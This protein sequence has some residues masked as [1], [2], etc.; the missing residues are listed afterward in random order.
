ME[1]TKENIID[2]WLKNN[3]NPKINLYIKLKIMAENLKYSFSNNWK[4]YTILTILGLILIGFLG[5][6]PREKVPATVEVTIP[7]T[8]GKFESVKPKQ[9][10]INKNYSAEPKYRTL[11]QNLSEKERE[12]FQFQLD[13]LIS[14]NTAYEK[15]FI[16]SDSV[17]KNNLYKEAIQLKS[18]NQPFENDKIKINA[19]GL[20]RGT[21]ESIGFDYEIKEQKIN[22]EIPRQKETYLRVLAGGGFGINKA[23]NQSV[24]KAN[25]GF[26]NKKGNIVR[27]SFQK[28]GSQDYYLAEY[29]ISI[30]NWKR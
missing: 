28:I 2:R 26:Q 17:K 7:A 16:Y 6:C 20:V 5:G 9:E 18:F 13:S 27:G 1:F 29:D 15:E 30:L 11:V 12:F 19:T 24:W 21:I 4:L 3:S 25:I 10:P 14:L 23:L 22:V 8:T